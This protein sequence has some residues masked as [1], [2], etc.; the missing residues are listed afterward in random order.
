ML[1]Q[2]S[3]GIIQSL[4]VL[5]S[6]KPPKPKA[7]GVRERVTHLG[8]I[9]QNTRF[10]VPESSGLSESRE[11]VEY[12]IATAADYD[13]DDHNYGEDDDND[14]DYGEECIKLEVAWSNLGDKWSA[15]RTNRW[16]GSQSRVIITAAR[17][18]NRPQ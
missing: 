13:D 2:N 5:S 7:K 18:H 15:D 14:N 16:S 10:F 9:P 6:R 8:K 12:L 17:A 11:Y 4:S 3:K 1:A